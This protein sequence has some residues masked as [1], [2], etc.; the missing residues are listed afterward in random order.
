MCLLPGT[1]TFGHQGGQLNLVNCSRGVKLRSPGKG[2]GTVK[3]GSGDNIAYEYRYRICEETF[4]PEGERR[5]KWRKLIIHAMEQWEEATA[6][7]VVMTHDVY[8]A[9]EVASDPELDDASVDRGKPC[10]N[11]QK[12]IEIT[13]SKVAA[14]LHQDLNQDITRYVTSLL[15]MFRNV[16]LTEGMEP[17][18]PS[19]VDVE[20]L[21]WDLNEIIMFD[22]MGGPTADLVS[23]R[24]FPE[25]ASQLGRPW[26]WTYSVFACA[27]IGRV[28]EGDSVAGDTRVNLSPTVVLRSAL[29]ITLTILQKTP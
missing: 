14:A 17:T 6:G 20:D 24:V 2:S 11:Y 16:N 29:K 15:Q 27:E 28:T 19:L 18:D 26:C 21:D 12:F 10:A 5:N 23:D 22:D 25:F 4:F 8:T 7:L 13:A 3:I 9:Q 1:C